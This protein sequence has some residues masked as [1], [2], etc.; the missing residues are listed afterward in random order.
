MARASPPSARQFASLPRATSSQ[1]IPSA[2]EPGTGQ[3]SPPRSALP[4]H[5]DAVVAAA[6]AHRDPVA[7]WSLSDFARQ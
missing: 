3:H 5:G 4:H 7:A 6:A 2:R 1:G